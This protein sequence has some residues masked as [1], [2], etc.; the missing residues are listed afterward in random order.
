MSKKKHAGMR[1]VFYLRRAEIIV[2]AR[3]KGVADTEDLDRFLIAWFWHRLPS[4]NR[5]PIGALIGVAKRMGRDDFTE[6]EAKVIIRAS[7]CGRPLY[8]ADDLGEYLRLF[9]AERTKW[10]IKTIGACDVSRRERILRRKRQRRE[11]EAERRHRH[12]ARPRS[13]SLSR[14]KPWQTKGISRRTWERQQRGGQRNDGK[15][16]D[17]DLPPPRSSN[18]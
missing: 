17:G 15:A 7:T 8:K 14:T 10:G 4:A 11:R 2:I 3:R 9:D 6:A 1:V 18:Q 5:D 13:R 12:G 16:R